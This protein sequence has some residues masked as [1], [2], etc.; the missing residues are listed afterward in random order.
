MASGLP[1]SG[2]SVL[3]AA[4]AQGAAGATDLV[5]AVAGQLIIVTVI[6]VTLDVAGTIKFTEGT[7]PT[8]L[9]GPMNL[10]NTGQLI[11][12]GSVEEPVL[13]TKTPGAKL[14]ITTVTGK[15]SGYLRYVTAPPY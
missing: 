4:I 1:D 6:V 8:D 9:T 11:L 14:S 3:E 15:A 13:A 5:A 7:G 10:A 12:L 2:R